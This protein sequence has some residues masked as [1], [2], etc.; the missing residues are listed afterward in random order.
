MT[1]AARCQFALDSE[2]P[3]RPRRGAPST[4]Q[5]HPRTIFT[6]ALEHDKLVLAEVTAREIGRI[7]ERSSTRTC[8]SDEPGISDALEAAAKVG[9]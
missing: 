6:R 5:G 2:P 1:I 8:S 9:V 7:A 4:S 3:L